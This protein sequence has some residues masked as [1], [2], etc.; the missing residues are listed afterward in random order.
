MTARRSGG[1]ILVM[2]SY[3]KLPCLPYGLVDGQNHVEVRG[4]ST[5]EQSSTLFII[6]LDILTCLSFSL[7]SHAPL[8][9]LGSLVVDAGILSSGCG[10]LATKNMMASRIL[11]SSSCGKLH[12][13]TTETLV[14]PSS[15]PAG[16]LKDQ[17]PS[18]RASSPDRSSTA[19][20]ATFLARGVSPAC[21][22]AP[23]SSLSRIPSQEVNLLPGLLIEKL[24]DQLPSLLLPLP[25]GPP[26][27]LLVSWE[28][29]SAC[30]PAPPSL[31]E[32]R[33]PTLKS[34]SSCESD[35]EITWKH[36]EHVTQP[37]RCR[38][39]GTRDL[40]LNA[41]LASA[42]RM[43]KSFR[44]VFFL[45]KHMSPPDVSHY[46]IKICSARQ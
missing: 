29:S 21:K 40:K 25:K 41:R 15:I 16:S 12:R 42:V 39:S 28:R 26:Q 22:P 37:Y 7:G 13:L 38:I 5:F 20:T 3:R 34:R 35:L 36:A 23:P 30:K 44:A 9:H 46:D 17:L 31:S 6:Q 24:A 14:L 11:D 10:P 33:P 18:P 1:Y 4:S 8:L 45:H 2:C 43:F 32:R 27:Q 19:A